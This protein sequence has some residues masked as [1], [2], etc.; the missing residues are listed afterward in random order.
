MLVSFLISYIMKVIILKNNFRLRLP[1]KGDY[2]R[3]ML[4]KSHWGNII[5]MGW[6]IK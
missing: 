3:G 1:Y 4:G 5:K 6:K 2:E